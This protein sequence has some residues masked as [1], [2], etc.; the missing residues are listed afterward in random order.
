MTSTQKS[1]PKRL[2]LAS[3]SPR[4]RELLDQIDA[5]YEVVDVEVDESTRAGESPRDY[6]VRV[7]RDKA[8]EAHSALPSDALVLA[9]DTTVVLN[10]AILGK[11]ENTN[12]ALEMLRSLSGQTHQVMTAIALC[13]PD[14]VTRI[15]TSEVRFSN[16]N[17]EE[18]RAYIAT[19]EP[20]DKAGAYA[21]QGRAAV[22]VEHLQG[23]YSGVMG[24]P[25]FEVAQLLRTHGH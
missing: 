6:V 14:C 22:F 10:D 18:L 25:L 2:Y 5:C 20:M 7:A 8:L 23:S 24:L 4:R 17:D 1:A 11:P 3:R 21:I 16:I 12:H 19:G 15:S 9:A 13:A